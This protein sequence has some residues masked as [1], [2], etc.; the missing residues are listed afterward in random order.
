MKNDP[1]R[2]SPHI[3]PIRA[4]SFILKRKDSFRKHS[5]EAATGKGESIR[6]EGRKKTKNESVK[7][8]Q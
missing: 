3:L 4:G 1:K 8:Y 7:I 5:E 2:K 6:R